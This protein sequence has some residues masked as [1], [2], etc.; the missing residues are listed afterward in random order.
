MFFCG[1][2]ADLL[3]NNAGM[4]K[5]VHHCCIT[6]LLFFMLPVFARSQDKQPEKEIVQQKD[7]I[8]II[9]RA[10][11]KGTA[12]SPV[13]RA[14]KV[15][16]SF[17]PFGTAVA[18]GGNA[19]VTSTTAGFYLGDIAGTSLS[20]AT[21]SP[22][23]TFDGRYGYTLRTSIYLNQDRWNIKGDTR[24]LYYPQYT[25]GLGGNSSANKILMNYS[26]IRFYQTLL[27]KIRPYLFAG[28]GYH[29]DSH[30]D[31]ETFS[32]SVSLQKFT[33][34]R[35]G[36]SPDKNSF[37][38]GVSLNLLYDGRKNLF[39]PL[40]G[41]YGNIV[42]RFNPK[43][44][45]SDY[46]WHSL[47]ADL[48]RYISFSVPEKQNMLAFW[49][50]YWT[51]LNQN[52]PYLDLPSIGWDP[53]RQRSGRGFDQ[54]R[55]RGKG[56]LYFETEYRKDITQNGLLGFVLFANINSISTPDSNQFSQL[57][58]A[59]GGG[60]RFKFNKKSGTNIALD[61]GFSKNHSGIS[62]NLGETF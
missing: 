39:N 14:K 51:A 3:N 47:Y 55:Y 16:F 49:A 28:I 29:L 20:A 32:D 42:Y 41:Y 38:S 26:Y 23:F 50:F 61:Y 33:G 17:L 21:F 7:I 6:V 48:R 19:L 27:R 37:S 56:L 45:G 8:D 54:N 46:N 22:Y 35:Y 40:P 1:R 30:T 43:L 4:K 53:Y 13:I 59:A 5:R 12:K 18:G 10:F 24:F 57:H 52:V 11:H 36:T 15:Y 34:Y 9:G 58:P 62:I 31:I 2:G 25:W 44:L 60:L